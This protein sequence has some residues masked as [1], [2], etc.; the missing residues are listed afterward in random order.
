MDSNAYVQGSSYEV[1]ICRAHKKERHQAKGADGSYMKNLIDTESGQDLRRLVGSYEKQL[2]QIKK[3]MDKALD[4]YLK[5]KLTADERATI[6]RLKMSLVHAGDSQSLM[7][8]VEAGI[9]A[10]QRFKEY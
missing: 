3:Y 1:F 2:E 4:K 8:I 9:D 5:L 7:A 10:T 6:G